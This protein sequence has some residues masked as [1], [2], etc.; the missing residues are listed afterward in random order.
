MGI[1]RGVTSAT[2]SP[3]RFA[4]S[5]AEWIALGIAL[6]LL[7][8]QAAGAGDALDYRRE[9]L[10]REPWRIVSAHLVHI[11]WAHAA[12]N[13]A[14]L[15]IVARLFAP[16]LTPRQQLLVLALAALAISAALALLLPQIAWYRGLSGVL[17]AL[18]FAGA[19]KWLLEA[20]P[21]TARTL[22]LPLVLVLGGW[23][24]VVS[25]QP[26]GDVLPHVDWLGAAVV[27]Q[28]HLTGALVGS[29]LGVLFALTQTGRQQQA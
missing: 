25:E 7:L 3:R 8:L 19:T 22:A 13:A 4:L 27:P 17:H 5:A 24:K 16:D 23:I 21:R 18:F 1:I 12:I 2:G 14:A 9:L 11:N 29:A 20:Q 15:V 6:A 26:R 10:A 28:A